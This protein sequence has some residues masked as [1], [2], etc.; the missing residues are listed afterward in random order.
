M[1]VPADNTEGPVRRDDAVRRI[2]DRAFEARLNAYLDG[3]MTDEE[4]R[5][6][7]DLLDRDT[8]CAR[9]F[10]ETTG[11][12][13]ALQQPVGTPDFSAAVLGCVESRRRRPTWLSDTA[14]R[15]V[16]VGRL[17]V[18]ATLLLA[19]GVSLMLR[20]EAAPD[21]FASR[22]A[23]L[24]EAVA[25]GR[26]EAADGLRDVAGVVR[27]AQASFVN[28]VV[29]DAPARAALQPQASVRAPAHYYSTRSLVAPEFLPASWSPSSTPESGVV[30]GMIVRPSTG[31]EYAPRVVFLRGG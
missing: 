2:L 31:D 16:R 24:S 1:N 15:G 19:L 7:F 18:A 26:A 8:A 22:S 28:V 5:G 3:E 13:E 29:A 4:R 9:A 11:A 27:S 23:P 17:A 20:R 12:L 21:M 25:V 14:R 10:A 30:R 6:F